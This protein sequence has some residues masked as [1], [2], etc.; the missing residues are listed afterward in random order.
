M[1]H[2]I[3]TVPRRAAR[4]GAAGRTTGGARPTRSGLTPPACSLTWGDHPQVDEDVC[5]AQFADLPSRSAIGDFRFH[6]C[7]AAS[8]CCQPPASTKNESLLPFVWNLTPA[9]YIGFVMSIARWAS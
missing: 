7:D 3:R 5:Q 2:R 1:P 8:H 4:G 9:T 6:V